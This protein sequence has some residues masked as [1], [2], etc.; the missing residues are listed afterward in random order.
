MSLQEQALT[1]SLPKI[2]ILINNYNY[3]HFLPR[4]IESAL[5]QTYPQVEVIVVDDGSTDHSCQ[6]IAGYGDRV[7]PI[8]KTNGGQA[9]AINAGFLASTGDII[10]LLDSDDYF[11]SQ[12]AEEISM[13]FKSHPQAG[14]FFHPLKHVDENIQ[15]LSS[16]NIQEAFQN[17][18]DFRD[19]IQKRGKLSFYAP[20]TSG[21]CFRRYLLQKIL[22]M[23]EGENIS[24]SDHYIKFLAMGLSPGVQL[25]DQLA[26]QIVHGGNA[27]TA[28]GSNH[29]QKAKI[30]IYTAY[31][32]KVNFPQFTK[33]ADNLFAV[34]LA[35]L[36][37][38]NNRES[39][40]RQ[41]ADRY[42]QMT[43][44]IRRMNIN[45]RVFYHIFC[46]NLVQVFR[47]A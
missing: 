37:H 14:W 26:C 24:I 28:S 45:F 35:L 41:V 20:A 19:S 42:L 29:V 44:P 40:S 1:S 25:S 23:P 11:L 34:G 38:Q 5:T 6:V 8:L 21:L 15:S 30:H 36:N 39:T 32:M 46:F 47:G 7:I 18:Y 9:S 43:T 27:Y 2:S 31:W 10:C 33:F 17:F 4:A 16:T 12:K 22:P 13:A 3:A